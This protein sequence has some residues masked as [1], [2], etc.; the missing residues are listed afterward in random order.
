MASSTNGVGGAD[1]A[2]ATR[3]NGAPGPLLSDCVNL[4][5]TTSRNAQAIASLPEDAGWKQGTSSTVV[6]QQ[7]QALFREKAAL[8]LLAHKLHT[9]VKDAVAGLTPNEAVQFVKAMGGA[10]DKTISAPIADLASKSKMIDAATLALGLP[11]NPPLLP[12][13]AKVETGHSAAVFMTRSP[14]LQQVVKELQNLW[15]EKKK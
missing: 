6:A 4:T 2:Q 13:A 8:A 1:G 15:N 7:R 9:E 11:A 3:S 14:G 5:N 12:P 10:T